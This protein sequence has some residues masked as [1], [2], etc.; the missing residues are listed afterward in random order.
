MVRIAIVDDDADFRRTLS[1]YTAKYFDNEANRFSIAC[2]SNGLD[3]LSGYK[4]EYDIVI[5][6]IQMPMMNGMDV[7]GRLRRVDPDVKLIFITQVE[8]FAI[9]GYEVAASDYILK[10]IDYENGFEYKFDR[11]VKSLD[12]GGRRT[13]DFLVNDDNG[14]IVRVSFD[15]LLYV[16]KERDVAVFV[17][18]RGEFR[19]RMNISA[20]LELLVGMPVAAVNSGCIVNFYCV[21]NVDG[22]TVSL[23]NGD[24]L[25]LS[26]GKKK[27]FYEKFFD[28]IA[29]YGGGY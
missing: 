8:N 6:D 20:V 11:V 16:V 22:H 12:K 25:V 4:C 9:R 3:F 23:T 5:L 28:Y 13:R 2:F 27:E 1:E 19:K 15:E 29:K 18:E 26:R 10:P 14:V 21:K 24:T 7:A 17:T